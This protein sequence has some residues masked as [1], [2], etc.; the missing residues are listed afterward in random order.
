MNKLT[1]EGTEIINKTFASEPERSKFL[2]KYY[3]ADIL[4][5]KNEGDEHYKMVSLLNY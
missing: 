1:I 2:K 5:L 4:L 3:K